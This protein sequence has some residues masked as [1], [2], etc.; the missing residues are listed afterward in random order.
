MRHPSRTLSVCLIVAAA[1]AC[2]NPDGNGAGNASN[3]AM[4][5]GNAAATPPAPVESN[6]APAAAVNEAAPT[7]AAA[8]ASASAAYRAG[9]S[10]PFWAL[11]IAGGEMAYTAADGPNVT[12]PLPA[13]QPLTNGYRYQG[14]RL[15]VTVDHAPCEAMDETTRP[16]TVTVVVDG[17]TVTGC[18]G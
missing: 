11:S 4:P 7:K 3:E 1:A 10:E 12:E 5:A 16:D 8:P 6:A 13:Q 14:S 17:N 2:S 15:T 9:G 18:G